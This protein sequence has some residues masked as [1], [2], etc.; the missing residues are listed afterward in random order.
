MAAQRARQVHLAIA[1]AGYPSAERS[2]LTWIDDVLEHAADD[3]VRRL[4]RE[5]AVEPLPAE[6][7]QDT[8]YAIGMIARLLE[9][10][11]S[12]RIEDLRGRLQR[13]DP[14]AQATEYQQ[15]FADLLA[16]EDIRRS[17]RQD[18]LGVSPS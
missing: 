5:L 4:V 17:L 15:C 12:R 18:A 9:L 3:E 11:A 7:G 6:V 2:G 1:G 10:D 16:L 14:V 8:Q 13:I